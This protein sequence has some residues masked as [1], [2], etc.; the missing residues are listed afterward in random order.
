MHKY[1]GY[2]YN[3][4]GMQNMQLIDTPWFPDADT[5]GRS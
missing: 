1:N 5:L 3:T 2:I 4:I